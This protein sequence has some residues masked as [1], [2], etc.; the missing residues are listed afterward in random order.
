VVEHELWQ[1]DQKTATGSA[2]MIFFDYNTQQKLEI[3]ADIR[4]ELQKLS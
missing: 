4:A 1:R 3:P 2:V